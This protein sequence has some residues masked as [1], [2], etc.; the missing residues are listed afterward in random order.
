MSSAP[1]L[2]VD[3]DLSEGVSAE[4]SDEQSNYLARVLRLPAGASVRLF[5][6]K[7]GE[8]T[9]ELAEVSR[10][11]VTVVV[12]DQFRA[13]PTGNAVSIDLW[14]AP[15]KKART[16]FIVE[17]ATELGALA[18]RPVI[19]SRTQSDR[20]RVDR[21]AKIA[22]EAAEQTERLDLPE[23]NEPL[24]LEKALTT[25][26]LGKSLIF[27]DEAGDDTG[28]PWGGETGRARP[29][30]EALQALGAQSATLLVG[31]EGGFTSEE[32][33][34]LREKEFVCPVTLGPRILRAETAVVAGL[35]VW[36][37]VV[38]DWGRDPYLDSVADSR[39]A[40]N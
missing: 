19:T 2:F 8:W 4:L 39:G 34:S 16:D 14:F 22:L 15:V 18:I 31:P 36:Q 5:N 11:S 13:Q 27:C 21:L 17:K 12:R 7:D 29:I 28:Q 23:I 40:K 20:V 9:C 25:L 37:S 30:R 6:G 33:A 24:T 38:G 1:R 3:F 35:A 10:R 26:E 32:R